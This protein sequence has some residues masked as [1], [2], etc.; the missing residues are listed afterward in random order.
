MKRSVIVAGALLWVGLPLAI[1]RVQA[2]CAETVLQL[3]LE[4]KSLEPKSGASEARVAEERA[5]LPSGAALNGDH[6]SPY[7]SDQDQHIYLE[8]GEGDQHSVHLLRTASA[9]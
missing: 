2:D 7:S 6:E 1:A 5:R 8:F 9:P 4:L 3:T